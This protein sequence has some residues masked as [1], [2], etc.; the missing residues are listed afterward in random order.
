MLARSRTLD[1]DEFME[2][3]IKRN[4]GE[5]EFHQAVDEVAAS[6]IPF[7]NEQPKYIEI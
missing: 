4:P 3:L 2:G 1:H 6:V 5:I 7:I